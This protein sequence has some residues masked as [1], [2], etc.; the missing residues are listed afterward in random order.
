CR[1]PRGTAKS[2]GLADLGNSALVP[3]PAERQ[4]DRAAL[5]KIPNPSCPPLIENESCAPSQPKRIGRPARVGAAFEH[6]A[7]LVGD[8]G[9]D[10]AGKPSPVRPPSDLVA[11][12]TER[13]AGRFVDPA[14]HVE[15]A[16]MIGVRFE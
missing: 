9:A 13:L 2:V 5:E 6:A 3:V 1:H 10:G 11:K 12:L 7:F 4:P 8:N 15:Q 14:L 16:R